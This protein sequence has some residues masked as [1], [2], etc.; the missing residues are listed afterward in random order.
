MHRRSDASSGTAAPELQAIGGQQAAGSWQQAAEAK[1]GRA[2]GGY[3]SGA[4]PSRLRGQSAGSTW[5]RDGPDT[6][7]TAAQRHQSGA[8]A[9]SSRGPRRGRST[10]RPRAR[11]GRSVVDKVTWL[12]GTASK[13]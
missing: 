9:V 7:S 13:G 11:G 10:L 8:K 2:R 12:Y 4:G 6:I 5:S 1:R 3:Y